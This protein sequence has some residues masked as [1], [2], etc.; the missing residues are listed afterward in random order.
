MRRTNL[1]PPAGVAVTAVGA[2]TASGT[3][4]A[5]LFE[6]LLNGRRPLT[7]RRVPPVANALVDAAEAEDREVLAAHVTDPL[8]L[9]EVVGARAARALSRDSRLLILAVHTSGAEWGADA[10]RT[11]VVLGTL[12][13]GRN[14]YLAI[15]DAARGGAGRVNPVWGPQAGYNAPAAQLSIHLTARGPNLTLSSGTTAGLDAL[16][17]GAGQVL[18][19]TCDA[20]VAAG[21]DTLSGAVDGTGDAAPLPPGE[22]AAV[23]VLEDDR[24]AAGR[25][26]A[27]VLGT[28]QATAE[29]ADGMARVRQ[30]AL[31][32]AAAEAVRAALRQAGRLPTEVALAVAA[33]GADPVAEAA[34]LA[35]L[36]LV[37]D[38]KL[39]LCVP[40]ATTG[41]TGG[42][43]GA[44]AAVVAVEALTR[45]VVPP[46]PGDGPVDGG[47]VPLT[48]PLGIC[49]AVDPG[50]SATA[51]LL[52][53]TDM[54]T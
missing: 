18:G 48:G 37:F 47:A 49:L 31:A 51:V 33:S 39:P 54:K 11:G 35:A 34:Q 12:R 10:D 41:G 32:G 13:A 19:G 43:D 2:V 5:E 16:A 26:L 50:G 53:S 28:G 14:E 25:A 24:A 8:D 4:V 30:E 46:A 9:T 27:R 40:T 45:G 20:V 15:H 17:V 22:A 21:L 23:L 38:T 42:A 52:S 44:L 36:A 6:D 7:T 3:T 1:P 29:A